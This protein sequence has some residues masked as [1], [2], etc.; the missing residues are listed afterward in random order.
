M[1]LNNNTAKNPV[2]TPRDANVQNTN[3]KYQMLG[4][5]LSRQKVYTELMERKMVQ[6]LERQSASFPQ[7]QT[8]LTK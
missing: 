4:Q 6:V 5:E 8:H 3:S 1:H 7:N 2:K